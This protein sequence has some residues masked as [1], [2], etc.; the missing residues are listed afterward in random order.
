MVLQTKASASNYGSSRMEKISHGFNE[1]KRCNSSLPEKTV[2][3]YSSWSAAGDAKSNTLFGEWASDHNQEQ[4][5]E[6]VSRNMNKHSRAYIDGR[7]VVF[8]K[9]LIPIFLIFRQV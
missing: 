3:S 5:Y 6:N 8:F 9:W 4:Q 2:V 7:V 1:V